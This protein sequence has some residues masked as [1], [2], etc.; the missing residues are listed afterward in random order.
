MKEIRLPSESG[1]KVNT[2][3]IIVEPYN[4][5]K[6]IDQRDTDVLQSHSRGEQSWWAI[7]HGSVGTVIP[8]EEIDALHCLGWW[9]LSQQERDLGERRQRHKYR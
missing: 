9:P 8:V 3:V 7:R 6:M 2:K 4:Y 5:L 1:V